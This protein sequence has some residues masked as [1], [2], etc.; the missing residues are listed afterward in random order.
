MNRYHQGFTLLELMIVV[1]IVGILASIAL[2]AYQG[3]VKRA[4]YSEVVSAMNPI[5]TAISVCYQTAGALSNCD[6]MEKIG[7]QAPSKKTGALASIGITAETAVILATPNI[8]RG[9]TADDTCTLE[10][11]VNAGGLDWVFSEPCVT[12]GYIKR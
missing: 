3:Y 8:Y 5:K 1:A 6:S 11:S 10:P 4:A 7:M 9:L 12:M 2:P